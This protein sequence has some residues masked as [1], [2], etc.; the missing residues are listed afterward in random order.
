MSIHSNPN[1]QRWFADSQITDTQG[2][3]LV[4]YHGADRNFTVFECGEEG[5]HFGSRSQARTMGREIRAFYLSA[6]NLFLLDDDLQN[7]SDVEAVADYLFDK[8]HITST[9]WRNFPG[10]QAWLEERG[11]DGYCYPNG[12]EYRGVSY[13]VFAPTQIKSATHN[14][15]TFNPA[16]PDVTDGAGYAPR[17][18]REASCKEGMCP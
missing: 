15:G 16:D 9:E 13:A 18:E 6:Q 4:V 11:Y 2:K 14:A 7:W 17:P 8:G 3:P 10:L 12:Y 1:F 5:F